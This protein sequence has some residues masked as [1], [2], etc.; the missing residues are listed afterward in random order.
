MV[1]AMRIL[2]YRNGYPPSMDQLAE[3]LGFSSE[4]TAYL[5]RRLTEEDIIRPVEGAFGGRWSVAEYLKLE[6]LPRDSAEPTQLDNALQ[7]FQAEKN[8]MAQKIETIKEQQALKKKDLF[9]ELEKK[10][11]KDISKK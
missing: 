6:D 8:K 10:I 9:A 11:K 3:M 1:A 5:I 2:E 4:Q 7:K